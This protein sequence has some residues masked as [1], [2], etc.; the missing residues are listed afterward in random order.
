MIWISG[1]S[2][3][4]HHRGGGGEKRGRMAGEPANFRDAFGVEKCIRG[5][6]PVLV[7]RELPLRNSSPHGAFKTG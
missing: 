1:G 2:A 4:L 3:S 7:P 5:L 6:R